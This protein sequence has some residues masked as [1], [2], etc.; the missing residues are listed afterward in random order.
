MTK[1]LMSVYIIF[2]LFYVACAGKDDSKRTDKKDTKAATNQFKPDAN[3]DAKLFGNWN[4]TA[5]PTNSDKMHKA[6]VE[7]SGI[8]IL[9]DSQNKSQG[10]LKLTK[11]CVQ[12][13]ETNTGV[14]R[15]TSPETKTVT[16][17]VKARFGVGQI[18]ISEA[19][20]GANGNCTLAVSAGV[21]YFK[22]ASDNSL[23]ITNEDRSAIRNFSRKAA[24]NNG[25]N[26]SGSPSAGVD[27]SRTPKGTAASDVNEKFYGTWSTA[28]GVYTDATKTWSIISITFNKDGQMLL[29]NACT[30]D[31]ED[32]PSDA[33]LNASEVASAITL[34]KNNFTVATEKKQNQV[35]AEK[36]CEA[37]IESGTHTY[38]LKNNDTELEITYAN[39]TKVTYKKAGT[40]PPAAAAP[41]TP[42]GATPPAAAGALRVPPPPNPSSINQRVQAP[43]TPRGRTIG[44]VAHQWPADLAGWWEFVE[45]KN[46]TNAATKVVQH[47]FLTFNGQGLGIHVACHYNPDSSKPT[48][49]YP[50]TDNERIKK[51]VPVQNVTTEGFQISESV[52]EKKSIDSGKRECSLSISAGDFKYAVSQDKKNLELTLPNN[53][54]VALKKYQ[55]QNTATAVQVPQDL[56]GRWW[57]KDIKNQDNAA[58]KVDHY[59][60]FVFTANSLEVET[61]CFYLKDASK[62]NDWS[63]EGQASRIRVSANIEQVTTGGFVLTQA[64]SVKKQIDDGKRECSLDIPAGEIKLKITDGK[65]KLEVTLSNQVTARLQLA[66]ENK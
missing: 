25:G 17:E 7:I 59:I 49:W 55:A 27:L 53:Q 21:I 41:V 24:A 10:T 65:K 32:S 64:I 57:Y 35:K 42:S 52:N 66:T 20:N 40:T 14:A 23:E 58:K 12:R 45:T 54:K 8:E 18:E 36:S 46:E 9:Q 29:K 34:T 1:R 16:V 33:I 47:N 60:H 4:A 11:T 48:E 22:L 15:T 37:K 62:G 56:V 44:P 26:R 61:A 28:P 19:K 39:G 50:I 63:D 3:V 2:A 31:I 38:V 6:I 13:S 30:H 5:A 43:A 51:N